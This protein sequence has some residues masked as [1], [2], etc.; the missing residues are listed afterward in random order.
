MKKF[1]ILFLMALVPALT[2]AQNNN[3]TSAIMTFNDAAKKLQAGN[4]EGA[5]KDLK[6]AAGYIDKAK[7]HEKTMNDPK[8]MFYVGEI[9]TTLAGLQMKMGDTEASMASAEKGVEGYKR[10]LA[11]KNKNDYADKVTNKM[12]FVGNTAL[13]SGVNLFNEKKYKEAY[14]MFTGARDA[15]AVIGITDTLAMY[16]MALSSER[17]EQYER[18][19]KHYEECAAIGYRGA[20]MYSFISYAYQKA[21]QPEKALAAIKTGREM[22][23]DDNNLIISE[24]NNF[25]REGKF[26]EAKDNLLLAIEKTPDN[27]VLYFSLG[28]VYDNLRS[29]KEVDTE[30]QDMFD[31][32]K[33][34]YIKAISLDAEY[35]DANYNLGALYFNYGVE[36]NNNLPL[37]MPKKEYDKAK[38]DIDLIFKEAIPYLEKA[39]EL[40]PDDVNTLNSLAQLYARTNQTEKYNDA[41]AKIKELSN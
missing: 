7:K 25:L 23:P 33:A 35:F 8:T 29:K 11:I 16:N 41:K 32:A 22:Y 1:A 37:D 17:G 10:C 27:P 20:S 13:N 26:E 12:K 40:K 21:E 19:A 6:E 38:S 36:K 24:L 28:S 3:R 18:A 5:L 15:M 34:A 30:K 9:H 14:E 39:N 2:F 31:K 4:E